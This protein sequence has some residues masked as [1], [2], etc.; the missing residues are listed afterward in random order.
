MLLCRGI[1]GCHGASCPSSFANLALL[2]LLGFS[3]W[4]LV[5]VLV[6]AG[7]LVSSQPALRRL[8]L[9]RV[10]DWLGHPFP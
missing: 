9:V 4:Q 3:N 10:P 1:R 2:G 6:E 8:Q 5:R 7:H